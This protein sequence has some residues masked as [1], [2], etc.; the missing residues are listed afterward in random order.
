MST[1]V[2]CTITNN[3]QHF[4]LFFNL[5]TPQC[6]HN[7][8]AQLLHLYLIMLWLLWNDA[9]SARSHHNMQLTLQL[10][11]VSWWILW[12][13]FKYSAPENNTIHLCPGPQ[14]GWSH[15]CSMCRCHGWFAIGIYMAQGWCPNFGWW[16]CINTTE[17]W[18]HKCPYHSRC[19]EIRC[20]T[21]QVSR[22]ECCS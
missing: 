12:H 16:K 22:G 14:R 9:H 2:F 8:V 10:N 15:K 3:S 1:T 4:F 17:W 11:C 13:C 5:T 6:N 7:F 18:V 19:E 20:R 21:L